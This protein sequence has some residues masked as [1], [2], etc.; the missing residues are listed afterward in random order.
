PQPRSRKEV[1]AETKRSA[2]H[3]YTPSCPAERMSP[4]SDGTCR[5]W[6]SA[7]ARSER[8]PVGVIAGILG[9]PRAG[10]PSLS[11]PSGPASFDRGHMGSEPLASQSDEVMPP[12]ED[13]LA[14]A[15]LQVCKRCLMRGSYRASGSVCTPGGT[16][17]P[18]G[19]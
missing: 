8:A 2:A 6:P 10:L 16:P 7:V 19:P 13:R 17:P 4:S 14:E 12:M 11:V 1:P 3:L 15:Y 5:S 9:R 18:D